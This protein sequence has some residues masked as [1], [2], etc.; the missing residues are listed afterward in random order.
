MS[1]CPTERMGKVREL[2][3]A[4][5]AGPGINQEHDLEEYLWMGA[6][7]FPWTWEAQKAKL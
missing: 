7:L 1:V 3:V 5:K 6:H 2:A 4:L